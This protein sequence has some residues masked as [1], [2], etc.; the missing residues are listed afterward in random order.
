MRTGDKHPSLQD[1]CTFVPDKSP[2]LLR[3]QLDEETD[4]S[5]VYAIRGATEKA[6][7]RVRNNVQADEIQTPTL[8]PT[9]P[10]L[11]AAVVRHS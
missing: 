5:S 1:S 8:S 3:S 6:V 9:A 2:L 11:P 4:A 10:D 7:C